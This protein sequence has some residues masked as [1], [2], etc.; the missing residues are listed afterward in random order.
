MTL[1]AG[2][3]HA[4]SLVGRGA[5]NRNR[6]IGARVPDRMADLRLLQVRHVTRDAVTTGR[7]STVMRVRVRM[8]RL[9]RMTRGALR[10]AEAIRQRHAVHIASDRMPMSAE[11]PISL[12]RASSTCRRPGPWHDSQ[13]MLNAVNRVS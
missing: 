2:A 5:R 7:A 11:R 13:F 10:V 12:E 6:V 9:A 1:A 8:L 4:F 3:L